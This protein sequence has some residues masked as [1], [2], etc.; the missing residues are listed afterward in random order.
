MGRSEG[1]GRNGAQKNKKVAFHHGGIGVDEILPEKDR[2]A[3]V[4]LSSRRLRVPIS[5]FGR[6]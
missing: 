4:Q 1:I 2:Q 3:R 5:L 6:G